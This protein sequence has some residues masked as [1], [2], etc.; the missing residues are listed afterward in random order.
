LRPVANLAIMAA[1]ALL[2][3][4]LQILRKLRKKIPDIALVQV[5]ANLDQ[6]YPILGFTLKKKE[7]LLV[8]IYLP[9]FV[10]QI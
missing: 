4:R 3:P 6:T 8:K 9:R 5:K 10:L 7:F 1:I 2:F